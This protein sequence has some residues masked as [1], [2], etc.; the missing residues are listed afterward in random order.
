M[1]AARCF[2]NLRSSTGCTL[3]RSSRNQISKPLNKHCKIIRKWCHRRASLYWES[4][5]SNI[6][7]RLFQKSTRTY[8]L[9]NSV[10]SSRFLLARQ[11]KLLHQWY[12]KIESM[13][14]LIKKRVLLSSSRRRAATQPPLWLST[15]TTVR[16][17]M[18]API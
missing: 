17:T 15:P 13:R 11:N 16:F 7:S 2:S 6:T 10:A 1:S 12:L 4:Q 9:R 18:Y 14:F 3:E 8:L 5:S